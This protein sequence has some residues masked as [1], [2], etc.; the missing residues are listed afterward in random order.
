MI[1]VLQIT[2]LVSFVLLLNAIT[3]LLFIQNA[4]PASAGGDC[5]SGD[6]NGDATVDITDPVHLLSYIF[7]GGPEPV[8]CAQTPTEVIVANTVD[9]NVVNVPTVELQGIPT[10]RIVGGLDPQN[11]ISIPI[12][13]P[14]TLP[15]E[16]IEVPIGFSLYITDVMG[17]RMGNIDLKLFRNDTDQLTMSTAMNEAGGT[18]AVSL[19]CPIRYLEGEIVLIQR[20]SGSGAAGTVTI[21]GF[22]MPTS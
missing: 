9:M 8:A 14:N 15:I 21:H 19:R 20:S 16:V 3:T 22:L 13:L 6:I 4:I 11:A 1:K 5:V 2:L 17:S 7:E 18:N 10:V 12:S